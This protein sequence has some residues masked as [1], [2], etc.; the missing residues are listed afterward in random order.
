MNLTEYT[1]T[2]S[3]LDKNTKVETVNKFESAETISK[4]SAASLTETTDSAG[5]TVNYSLYGAIPNN[6]N[7][8]RSSVVVHGKVNGQSRI[9]NMSNGMSRNLL[10]ESRYRDL[11]YDISIDYENETGELVQINENVI[12]NADGAVTFNQTVKGQTFTNIETYVDELQKQINA[13]ARRVT[14]LEK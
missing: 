10:V 8:L 11:S 6:S 13:L 9:A 5:T 2:D 12:A 7:V 14:E 3:T 4:S 1:K